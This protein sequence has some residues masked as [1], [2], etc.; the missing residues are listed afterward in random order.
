LNVTEEIRPVYTDNSPWVPGRQVLR[1]NFDQ[2]F[3]QYPE[4]IIFGEDVGKI[5]GV[6]QTLEGL[7]AKYG[8]MRVTDTGIRE[9][10]IVGQGIGMAIRG[11]RPIAEI[12]YF[13][14][15]L[16]ALQTMSDDLATL[17]YRSRG[18]QK[19]PLI[20]STRG[21]RLEGIWHSGS[22][23]SMVINSIRGMYVL[24]PRN[25]TQ[26]AGFYNTLLTCDEPAL[27]IEPLNAYRLRE[28]LPEN[29]GHFRIPLG[30]P[31]IIQQGTDVTI[32]TYGS[33]V[34]IAEEALEQLEQ[35]GISAEVI[36]V[37]TLLPFDIHHVI[38][39]SL[40]KTSRILFFDEDVPGG[41][42]AYMMQKVLE[43]QKGFYHLD[44][45]PRTLTAKEHRPAYT[46]DGDYFSNPSA[47]D[48]F[49][50]AYQI[51]HEINPFQYPK[52]F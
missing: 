50:V 8:E 16:Y 23:L 13:D 24:V 22:P 17:Q 15:L 4:L 42:T 10:S 21:H 47:E 3:K 43:E 36:D 26:A 39:R 9:A 11:L 45:E 49:E 29:L 46:T 28:R 35:F 12:Q 2:L 32:V 33:C 27:V 30:I 37:Q 20:I 19:A 44:A 40:K 31:E 6:N 41:T 18:G 5:G 34:R 38:A 48:V 52:I 51:M 14:Y 1:D 25:L 7:Q